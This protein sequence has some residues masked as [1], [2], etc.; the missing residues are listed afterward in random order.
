VPSKKP[1]SSLSR[2]LFV[3]VNACEKYFIGRISGWAKLPVPT[4]IYARAF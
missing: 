2:R 1:I 3:G 4:S